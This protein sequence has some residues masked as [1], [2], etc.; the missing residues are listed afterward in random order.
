MKDGDYIQNLLNDSD[1][2]NLLIKSE[3]EYQWS[4]VCPNENKFSME[5]ISTS[6]RVAFLLIGVSLSNNSNLEWAEY[7]YK[8]LKNIRINNDEEKK[9]FENI[10][11]YNLKDTTL[12]Y[13]FYT[14]SLALHLDKTISARLDLNGY[15]ETEADNESWSNKVL[16]GIFKAL[17]FLIR[18][19]DGYAD[20]RKALTEIS[21]LQKEQADFEDTYL[22]QFSFD[23]QKAEALALVGLYH[24]SKALTET[25]EYLINGYDTKKRI[26]VVVRQH[27]DIALK[28]VPHETRLSDFISIISTDLHLLIKNSLWNGTAFQDKIKELCKLKSIQNNIL[29][30]LP[31][32]RQAMEQNLFDVFANATILQMP[33]SAGKTML[34]EFNIIVTKSL[35]R[36]A[37]I[38][39]VVPSRALVNQIYFDLRND[40]TPIGFNVER[41]S[42]ATEVDPTEADFL[43][44]DDVDILVSTPEKLDLLVRRSHPSVQDI[45]LF[46]ID[47]AHTIENGERGARLELLITMLRRERPNA[48]YMLLSPFL[49]GKK[50][51]LKEWLG[52][53]NMIQVDWKP[54]EKIVF[55][56]KVNKK[57]ASFTLLPSA[58]N[59]DIKEESTRH[60]DNPYDLASKGKTRI[61]EFSCQH[62]AQK[63]KT[64][65]ILCK[66]RASANTTAQTI[67]GWINE[68]ACHNDEIALVQK[69]MDEEIG[70]RTSFSS[71][72]SK[73]IA[74][75]H[76][77][78]SDESKLLT[79]HLIRHGLI[80]YVCATSTIAEGVNFPVSSVY[81]DTYNRGQSNSLS[82]NDFW[83][84]AGRAG[85][86]LVDDFGK[87]ILPFNSP[88]NEEK[89]KSI[90]KKGAEQLC[91][92]LSE[93]FIRRDDVL[94]TLEKQ[95]S[96]WTL[97]K[98][99]PASF[100]PL[101]QYFVHL[102]NVSHNEYTVEIED[103]F[104]DS[105]AY[106]MLDSETKRAQFIALCKQ[107]YQTIQTQYSGNS[108]AMK[109]ADK[110]GFSVPS[111]LQIMHEKL[112][113]PGI[114]DLS[115][116]DATIMFDKHKPESLAEKIKAI[117]E[118]PE[119]KLGTDSP[120][121]PLSH[122]LIAKMIIAWVKGEKLNAISSIHPTFVNE[123]DLD[124][125][126]TDFITY[127]NSMRFKASWGLSALEGI[128]RGNEDEVR[129][130]YIPSY[131]YYGV[132]DKKA[133][134][135][136]MLGIPRS[137]SP[138]LSRI[139]DSPMSAYSF[140]KLRR[141][142]Q[143]LS[144]SDWDSLTPTTSTLSGA[145]WQRIVHILMK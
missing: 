116:W 94:T 141:R 45:S 48:K 139:I 118:L 132:D 2:R 17:F 7:A 124:K 22:N 23:S 123:N 52:G 35:R 108:G 36:D 67:Y 135:M 143:T 54:S 71:W 87:I 10:I 33:T 5:E 106:Y 4:S 119:T 9:I 127:M 107:I 99:Y 58:H 114:S 100:V 129:D 26:D 126:L 89:A 62:F 34:A 78:L 29:E 56:L 137:L 3:N 49:P 32:Q 120:K 50:E 85:R 24:T 95:Y 82:A 1:I 72:L 102:L 121:A 20:I 142:I 140:S 133:L 93:L 15:K 79:E 86:T 98:N 19:S 81:F 77:G 91:S 18:K 138:S 101:F 37:K 55:G 97:T 44:A 41:T 31:S 51:A 112:N 109:L 92:V 104:Q 28:L 16:S 27:I 84:I 113:N 25:A 74:V 13:Y 131:V 70:C 65:L 64:E 83:N 43:L 53:G 40:L 68:P 105:L 130:S 21:K 115:T 144:A 6:C 60:I 128:V 14:S 125:R 145:E 61:L 12:L 8:L 136:R 42:S 11:G 38:V 117:S 80:R 75:H 66:G 103:L 110:T 73:G 76:A 30:L 59:S 47:E 134:A 39:Y 69:F 96:L 122:K 63:G 90:L 57:T 88:E 46:I 111:V